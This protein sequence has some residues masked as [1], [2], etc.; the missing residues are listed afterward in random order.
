[1][2]PIKT[3]VSLMG[4][5]KDPYGRTVAEVLNHKGENINKK[6]LELGYAVVYP[7]QKGC[8]EYHEIQKKAKHHKLGVFSDP[9]FQNPWEYREKMVKL[10][11]LNYYK[12]KSIK[13]L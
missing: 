11:I 12:M 5:L 8:D 7:Y 10:I 4:C 1:M 9:T 6:M 13:T 2:L 3:N